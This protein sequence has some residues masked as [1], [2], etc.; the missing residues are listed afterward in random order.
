MDMEELYVHH[1]ER[2][3]LMRAL[4]SAKGTVTRELHWRKKD[5]SEIVVLDTVIT[6]RDEAGKVL[7]FD[8]IIDDI[9]ERKRMERE[10]QEREEQLEAQNEELRFV[11]EELQA[12]EEALRASNDEFQAAND[13]L[14]QE[15]AERK[16]A[17]KAIR[18]SEERYRSLVNNVKL[19][20]LRS[21]PGP[22]ERS[23][24]V[25]PAFEEITGYSRDELLAMDMEELYVDREERKALVRKL[26]LAKGTVTW[27]LRWRKKDGSEI[28]VL[29]TVITVRDDAGKILHFDSIFEDV[30]ERKQAEEA[31]RESEE[32][33]RALVNLRG[34]FGAAVIMLQDTK[35]A[36]GAHTFV[37][38]QWCHMTGYSREE[39]LE[40]PFFNL[41]HPQ[42]RVESLERH[43][44]K[45]RGE[46]VPGLYELS[47]I[48][49]DGTEVPIE[50]TGAYTTYKG[51]GANVAYI[52]DI[53]ERKQMEQHLIITDRLA[54]VGE[55]GSGI[56]HELNNPLTSVVGFSQLLLD[57][58]IPD[59][60][61]E[62]VR[63]ISSEAQR[64][65]GVVKTL[66]NKML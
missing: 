13:E 26:A 42:D 19:G 41:V 29:D 33:Y 66:L 15:V 40:M 60:I 47:I 48:T 39:L 3:A 24:E 23:L 50:L 49:N 27:E 8:A 7:H 53:T 32:R 30:T 16:R 35:Q 28:E 52:R 38:N 63:I 11:N 20:I 6:V 18:E 54:S 5:G 59:D 22:P 21:T 58:D 1:E 64:A 37:S 10:L 17:E 61:K 12:T 31:L 34:K 65:A 62:D 43:R 36:E 51:K 25:N 4:T 55:L 44:R 56:A 14:Q 45:M 9:T 46:A 2:E 57:K